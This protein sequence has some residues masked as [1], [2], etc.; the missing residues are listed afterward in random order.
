[1][2]KRVEAALG[3]AHLQGLAARIL[4]TVFS[5]YSFAGLSDL[6][7]VCRDHSYLVTI[8]AISGTPLVFAAVLSLTRYNDAFKAMA[9]HP[10]LAHQRDI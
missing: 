9:L 8:F 2:S 6:S 3:P 5:R 10:P 1:M 7:R 4:L